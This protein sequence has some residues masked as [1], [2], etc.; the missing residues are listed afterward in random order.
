MTSIQTR[1]HEEIARTTDAIDPA[2]IRF[3]EGGRYV[4]LNDS[5]GSWWQPAE[6]L[7]IMLCALPSFQPRASQQDNADAYARWCLV[8]GKAGIFGGVNI[9]DTMEAPSDFIDPD[10]PGEHPFD[11]MNRQE[12]ERLGVLHCPFCGGDPRLIDCGGW[13]VGCRDC[14]ATTAVRDDEEAAARAWNR[15]AG[16]QVGHAEA[17]S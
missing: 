3:T 17:D 1:L 10:A 7:Y 8:A 2:Q 6:P 16:L 11:R 14:G 9:T 12:C 5:N 4:W 13:H 15:R